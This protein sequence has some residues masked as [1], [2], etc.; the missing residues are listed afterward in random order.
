MVKFETKQLHSGFEIDN[1][2]ARA[3]PIYAT[4]SYIFNDSKHGADLFSLLEPGYIYSRIGNPTNATFEKRIADLENG[5]SAVATASGHAAQYLAISSLA[6]SGDNFIS[7]SYLYGGTYNQFSVY[8]KK[9]GIEARFVEGSNLDDYE[10]RIDDKTKLI[11]VESIGN[12]SFDV[13]D[14]EKLVALA[15]KHGIPVVVDNTFGAGGYVIRPID[16][17]AD[18]VVHSATKWISGNG[19][20]IA[21]VVIDS[22]KFPWKDHPKRFP[23]FSEPSEGYHGLIYNDLGPDAYGTFVRTEGLRDAGPAMN[24]FSA[25]LLLQGLETLSLRVERESENALKLA[26]YFEKSPYIKHVNYLG[27]PN[28]RTHELAKKYLVNKDIWGSVLSIEVKEF[29]EPTEPFKEA[30]SQV[31][32]NLKIF[33]NLANVGDSKSLAIVPYS[34]THSQLSEEAKTKAGVTKSGIRLSIGTEHIDDL[35]D[36]FEQSFAKVYNGKKNLK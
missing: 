22:G 13:P 27:L 35:I 4:S 2:R 29:D 30:A 16:H 8:F 31:V 14:F 21:G 6:F 36:D 19:T 28:H 1:T 18:I 10:K 26:N 33:S 7:S 25:F 32:D 3:V 15:H 17:G 20:T 24:P 11:F 12:P 23:Q 34:T 9:Y 5:R